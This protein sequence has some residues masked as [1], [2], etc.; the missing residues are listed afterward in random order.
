MGRPTKMKSGCASK[1]EKRFKIRALIENPFGTISREWE[2]E[3]IKELR[4][5]DLPYATKRKKIDYHVWDRG[6]GDFKVFT[7]RDSNLHVYTW[8]DNQTKILGG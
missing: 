8:V 5:T 7:G 4:K 3:D 2:V 6:T 1:N